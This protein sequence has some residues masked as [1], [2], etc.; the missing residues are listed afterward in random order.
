MAQ[1][2]S[3]RDNAAEFQWQSDDVLGRAS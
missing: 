3:Q 1:D 2:Q